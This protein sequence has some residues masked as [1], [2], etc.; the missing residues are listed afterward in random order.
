MQGSLRKADLRI[1]RKLDSRLTF[2]FFAQFCNI[3]PAAI[4]SLSAVANGEDP[5]R[6]LWYLKFAKVGFRHGKLLRHAYPVTL[7]ANNFPLR[8]TSATNL[9]HE[10]TVFDSCFKNRDAL[11]GGPVLLNNSQAR[12]T[13]F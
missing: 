13:S 1:F 6:E 8:K 11:K 5:G 3:V 2:T 9:G 10:H 7:L 12:L 4:Y